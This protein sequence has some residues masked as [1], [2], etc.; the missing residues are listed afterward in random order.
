MERRLSSL[1]RLSF[2]ALLG[3]ASA[4][5]C[6]A[7]AGYNDVEPRPP[8]FAGGASGANGA[9]GRGGGGGSSGSGGQVGSAGSAGRPN[10]DAR[11]DSE[12]PDSSGG[13]TSADVSADNE[14]QDVDSG[15][16]PIL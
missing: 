14:P 12:E 3:I 10:A 5:G 15:P 9:S 1:G 2:T 8:G 6:E 11:S 13:E 4:I 7:I 16:C